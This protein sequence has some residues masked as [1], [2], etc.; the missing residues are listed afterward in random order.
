[1]QFNPTYCDVVADIAGFLSERI[2]FL[3]AEGLALESLAIDPGIGFGKSHEHNMTLLNRLG[4]F[5]TLKRP[6]CLGVSRKGF[7]GQ[8]TGKPRPERIAGSVAVACDA[9]SR[10]TA[11]ILRVHDVAETVD[12][13]KMI[14]AIQSSFPV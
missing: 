12:A 13:V 1:M 14:E 3:V 11:Q 10:N 8:I 5:Q 4:E 9:I 2:R 7:I 6:V